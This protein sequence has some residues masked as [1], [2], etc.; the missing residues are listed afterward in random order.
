MQ[1]NVLYQTQ[2]LLQY[3]NYGRYALNHNMKEDK[4]VLKQEDLF[5]HKKLHLHDLSQTDTRVCVTEI[6]LQVFV[7]PYDLITLRQLNPG[8]LKWGFF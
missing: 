5:E 6:N 7:A 4:G 8:Y 3:T 2:C 1:A